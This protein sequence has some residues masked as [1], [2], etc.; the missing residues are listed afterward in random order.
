MHALERGS[1]MIVSA[2]MLHSSEA[3]RRDDDWTG[4]RDRAER[5][6]RQ[7]RLNVRAYSMRR[8]N[9]AQYYRDNADAAHR[10]AKG[11]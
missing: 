3:L 9:Q 4:L 1:Q 8:P 10:K 6:K 7:N 2:P 11:P 5:R